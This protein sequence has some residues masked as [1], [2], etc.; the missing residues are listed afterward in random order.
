MRGFG[1]RGTR[2]YG[3]L[4]EMGSIRIDQGNALEKLPQCFRF[5]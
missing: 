4:A 5:T 3:D 2:V 1:F